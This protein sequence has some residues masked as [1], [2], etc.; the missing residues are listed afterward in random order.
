MDLDLKLELRA[1]QRE[2]AMVVLGHMMVQ[3]WGV[4]LFMSDEILQRIVDCTHKHKIAMADQIVKETCWQCDYVDQCAGLVLAIIN[5]YITPPSVPA[6]PPVEVSQV[7]AALAANEPDTI[8]IV[9]RQ[10]QPNKC[11]ACKGI[12]HN[13][14]NPACPMKLT[15]EHSRIQGNDENCQPTAGTSALSANVVQAPSTPR[16]HYV[17]STSMWQA[18]TPSTSAFWFVLDMGTPTALPTL[19][20]TFNG[21]LQFNPNVYLHPPAPPPYW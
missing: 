14:D 6:P 13:R 20:Y 10:Q 7:L 2:Q 5:R 17:P 11:S 4:I 19:A 18:A 1:W 12:G 16:A 8:P 3:K 21:A 15:L 9:R